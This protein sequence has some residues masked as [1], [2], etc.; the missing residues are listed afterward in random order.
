MLLAVSI[1]NTNTAFGIFDGLEF[2]ASGTV[3]TPDI[4]TLPQAIGG[5]RITRIAL[6]SVVPSRTDQ[7]VALLAQAYQQTVEVVGRDIHFPMDI[8][9]DNP[10]AVGVDRLL[11]GVAAF[12]RTEAVVIVADVGTAI[13]VDLISNKGSFCGGA[14]APGPAT[15][16]GGMAAKGEQLPQVSAEP[17]DNALGRNTADA[18]RAGAW[19]SAVGTVREITAQ[20]AKYTDAAPKLLITGGAGSFVA[21]HIS[22]AEYIPHL[23]LQGIAL[24]CGK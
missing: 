11:N 21:N 4:A 7:A 13:T 23:T 2:T 18:M 19:Y 12:A 15:A 22:D 10:Q 20:L 14:I 24:L 6:A 5:A 9:C 17:P 8:Q 16:L 3:A 1:G